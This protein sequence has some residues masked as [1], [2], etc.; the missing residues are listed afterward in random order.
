MTCCKSL[1]QETAHA[2]ARSEQ[3]LI[4]GVQLQ[5]MIECAEVVEG[6]ALDPVPAHKGVSEAL[7]AIDAHDGSAVAFQP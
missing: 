2:D 5:L 3:R 6:H 4:D 1:V 7:V